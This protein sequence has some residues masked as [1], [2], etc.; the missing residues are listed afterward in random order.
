MQGGGESEL[1]AA[2]YRHIRT[3]RRA[4]IPLVDKM[5]LARVRPW[6]VD[7]HPRTFKYAASRVG[8]ACHV[9]GFT[10]RW[11]SLEGA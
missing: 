8:L 11:R 3:Q 4:V 5:N 9:F 1:K 2:L 10:A 6:M 7:L